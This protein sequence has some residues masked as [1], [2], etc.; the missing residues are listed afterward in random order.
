MAHAAYLPG[1]TAIADDGVTGSVSRDGN[2][3]HLAE[4]LIQSL[5]APTGTG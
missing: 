4:K 1:M 3:Q 5:S 2:P